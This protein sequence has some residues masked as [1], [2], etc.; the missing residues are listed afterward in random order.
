MNWNGRGR[1]GNSEEINLKAH[2]ADTC[3]ETD[4][5]RIKEP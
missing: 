1:H 3:E 5:R 2:T 4:P